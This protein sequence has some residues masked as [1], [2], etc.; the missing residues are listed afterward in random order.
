[1]A[2]YLL[3]RFAR[4]SQQALDRDCQNDRAKS[5]DVKAIGSG[6]VGKFGGDDAAGHHNVAGAQAAALR[7]R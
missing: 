2:D 1:M 7:A 5:L 3:D 4:G 6:P